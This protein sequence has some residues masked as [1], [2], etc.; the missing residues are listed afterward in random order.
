M[1]LKT[2]L[3]ADVKAALRGGD[4]PTLTVLRM[5]LAAIKQREIDSRQELDDPGVEAVISK[6]IKQGED[7]AKQFEDAGRPELAAKE[8]T[9]IEVL[10]S[11]LPQPLTTEAVAAL[12]DECIATTGAASVKDMGKVMAAIKTAAGTRVDMG[13]VSQQVRQRLQAG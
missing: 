7:A 12:I 3:E 5:T 9:E 8:Q 1:T 2:R 13:A 4:K 10:K 11:Y 6:M